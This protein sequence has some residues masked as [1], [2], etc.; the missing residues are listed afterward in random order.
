[1]PVARPVYDRNKSVSS[2]PIAEQKYVTKYSRVRSTFPDNDDYLR[3]SDNDANA[4]D[5]A[6]GAKVPTRKLS[7]WPALRPKPPAPPS[8]KPIVAS[9]LRV[10]VPATLTDPTSALSF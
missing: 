6:T 9:V 10:K 3:Q 4:N 5:A 1:M 2:F 8:V 7:N